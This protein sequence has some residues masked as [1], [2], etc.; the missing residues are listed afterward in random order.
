MPHSCFSKAQNML[1]PSDNCNV[2]IN[3]CTICSVFLSSIYI[4]TCDLQ[5]LCLVGTDC[6]PN[7]SQETAEECDLDPHPPLQTEKDEHMSARSSWSICSHKNYY[8][9]LLS[10]VFFLF[11][12]K[13]QK[14]SASCQDKPENQTTGQVLFRH[15]HNPTQ[16]KA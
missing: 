14:Q 2:C 3:K 13:K 5:V 12:E 16:R 15:M 9:R 6:P 11:F 8:V 4:E 10:F 7:L 1:P